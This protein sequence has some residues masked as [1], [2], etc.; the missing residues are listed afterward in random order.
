M[1]IINFIRNTISLQALNQEADL[2][3]LDVQSFDYVIFG[4]IDTS[5]MALGDV[6]EVSIYLAVDGVNS[7]KVLRSRYPF[8]S[9]EKAIYIEPIF[10]C[11]DCKA[12]LTINQIS[13]TPRSYTYV[14]VVA[15]I[16][17][18]LSEMIRNILFRQVP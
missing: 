3:A 2:I 16:E 7:I 6:L 1:G 14:L 15:P 17:Q 18:A 12:R 4:Y 5:N 9:V 8:S 11:R 10:V 13:G